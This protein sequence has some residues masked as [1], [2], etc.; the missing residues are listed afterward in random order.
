M[1]FL[2]WEK[3]K[4]FLGFCKQKEDQNNLQKKLFVCDYCYM[5][6]IVTQR[7]NFPLDEV[8]LEKF[9]GGC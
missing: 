5:Y 2:K 1:F 6:C 8:N 9:D 4:V 3:I 7:Q